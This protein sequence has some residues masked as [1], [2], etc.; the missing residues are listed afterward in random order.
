LWYS[1]IRYSISGRLFFLIY[2]NDLPNLINNEIILFA[3]D[4]T[5][6]VKAQT[7]I[8]LEKAVAETLLQLD[9]WFSLNGLLLN[10][11]KTKTIFFKTVDI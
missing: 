9:S 2:I 1:T 10:S 5:A 7:L 6:L 8:E 11:T 4:T 3:D